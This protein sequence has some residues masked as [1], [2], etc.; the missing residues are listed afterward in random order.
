MTS[1]KLD[2]SR[3]KRSEE[4]KKLENI[5][6]DKDPIRIYNSKI[7]YVGKV[8]AN[9]AIPKIGMSLIPNMNY[10]RKLPQLVDNAIVTILRDRNLLIKAGGYNSNKI[11]SDLSN[12][13]KLG[14]YDN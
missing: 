9:V 7:E 5:K 2:W 3:V 12:F 10:N 11:Y 14:L 8:Q 4:L 13:S 1:N 6:N